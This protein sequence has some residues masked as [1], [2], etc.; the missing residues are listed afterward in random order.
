MDGYILISATQIGNQRDKT[1]LDPGERQRLIC[2]GGTL[3]G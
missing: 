1:E 3:V 2:R